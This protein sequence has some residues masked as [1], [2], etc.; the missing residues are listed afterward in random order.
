[1]T[2][3]P[4][5][6]FNR[7]DLGL[8]GG[9]WRQVPALFVSIGLLLTFLGL[10]AALEQTGQVLKSDETG[11]A[12]TVSGLTTL[13]N[14]ASAKFIMSLTGLA[15]SIVFNIL[16]RSC[17]NWKDRALNKLCLD[18]ESGCKFISEQ[19]VLGE[20]LAQAKEQTTQFQAFSTEL[21][22]QIA[23][24]LKEDLPNAIRESVGEAMQPLIDNISRG[25]NQGIESLVGSVSGRLV[26]GVEGSVRE[27]KTL[28]ESVGMML[29][30]AAGRL[31]RSSETM[32][33]NVQDATG[34]LVERIDGLSGG[35][36]ASTA[37][38][39]NFAE[40]IEGSASIVTT[41]SEQLRRSSESLS[42]ATGPIRNSIA[43]IQASTEAMK[44]T[45]ERTE[46]I[47]RHTHEVIET[48]HVA[49]Q[50][51]LRTLDRSVTEFKDIIDRYREI[52]DRLGDAFNKI[53][54]DLRA[55]IE[56]IGAFERKVNEEFARA[57]NRLEA[58]IAQAEPFVPASEE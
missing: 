41:S 2:V 46:S 24:P 3:R 36:D 33:G 49:V 15:C 51:G 28:M 31:E 7:E 14:V 34:T 16:L 19:D 25:T 27:M 10:V 18:I 6:F 47:L 48:S 52:D 9:I 21:V 44:G 43:D 8:E 1:N 17:T 37:R 55:S 26:E 13:L 32:T 30:E 12:A 45:S 35:I 53:E 42:E 20:M 38:L 58:V 54:T 23:Q 50:D 11:D 40:A 22:A 29:G 39:G 5:I 57:L 56:E 4:D